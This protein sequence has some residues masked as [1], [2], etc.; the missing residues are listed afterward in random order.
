MP[1]ACRWTAWVMFFSSS[2]SSPE[3]ETVPGR[4][5]KRCSSGDDLVVHRT[6]PRVGS[7]AA[8]ASR[9][10]RGVGVAVAMAVRA[11]TLV[12][13]LRLARAE[14]ARGIRVPLR[15]AQAGSSAV[16]RVGTA[17]LE[18]RVPVTGP[19]QLTEDSLGRGRYPVPVGEPGRP[20]AVVV[21]NVVGVEDKDEAV[22]EVVE[23]PPGG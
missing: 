22:V 3:S 23:S 4:V 21:E 14:V 9:R 10:A 6:P 18:L 17:M 8:A 19:R 11:G 13:R 20:V 12:G 5:T 1:E 2:G 7:P 16:M 15:Q